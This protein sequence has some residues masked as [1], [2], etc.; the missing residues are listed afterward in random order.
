MMEKMTVMILIFLLAAAWGR[1]NVYAQEPEMAESD[2]GGEMPDITPEAVAVPVMMDSTDSL[3]DSLSQFLALSADRFCIYTVAVIDPV[4]Q[5]PV[6]PENALPVSMDVP[7]DYDTERTLISEISMDGQNP[8]RTE[9][10]CT[11]S[12]GQLVFETD[13]SG[14]YAVME[15]KVPVKLPATLEMTAKVEKLELNRKIPGNTPASVSAAAKTQPVEFQTS[16]SRTVNP[17]TGDDNTALIWGAVTVI[18]AAAAQA[19]FISKRKK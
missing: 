9:L 5:T 16:G 15:K 8:V 14:I 2:A 11:Y 12:G 19:A 17:Q 10:P 1:G 7:S 18:A 4:T 3:Y 6:Q 13:H